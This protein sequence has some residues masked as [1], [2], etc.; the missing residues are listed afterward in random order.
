MISFCRTVFGGLIKIVLDADKPSQSKDFPCFGLPE[1][2]HRYVEW[3]SL[4]R[5]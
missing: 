4:F 2:V 1:G 5:A 3:L